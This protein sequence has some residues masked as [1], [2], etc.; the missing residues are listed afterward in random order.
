M[1]CKKGKHYKYLKKIQQKMMEIEFGLN[2][3]G[4]ILLFVINSFYY[5]KKGITIS[6]FTAMTT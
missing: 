6:K 2:K 5:F 1:L 3:N 4:I